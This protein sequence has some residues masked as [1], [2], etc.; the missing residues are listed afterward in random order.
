MLREPGLQ[1][2]LN[3]LIISINQNRKDLQY[4]EF[5]D[6]YLASLYVSGRDDSAFNELVSRFGDK[7]FR[8]AMR[9]TKSPGSAEEVLQ[10]VFVKLIQKLGDFRGQS[11]LSTWIY[12]ITANECFNYIKITNKSNFRQLS[13][14]SYNDADENSYNEGFQIKDNYNNPED[15]AA[16]TELSE[17]LERAINELHEDYRVVYQL[18]DIEGLSNIEVAEALGLSLSAVKSRILRARTQLKS[19]LSKLFPKYAN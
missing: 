12:S 11:R 5:T 2:P 1:S 15:A 19:K 17:L 9:I 18:R 4:K 16:N 8:L 13:I 6:E 10:I 7:I 3:A 14:E